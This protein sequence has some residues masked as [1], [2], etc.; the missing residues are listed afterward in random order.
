LAWVL[1]AGWRLGVGDGDKLLGGSGLRVQVGGWG[2]KGV[3]VWRPGLGLDEVAYGF[4]GADHGSGGFGFPGGAGVNF[5]GD[6]AVVVFVNDFEEAEPELVEGV[7][8][9][10]AFE[11][12]V[13][14]AHAEIFAGAGDFG[15]AFVVGD[16]VG[17][18]G[19]HLAGGGRGF[20]VRELGEGV[21][22]PGHWIGDLRF[23][24]G[25]W[26]RAQG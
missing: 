13:L 9:E 4:F 3:L 10:M 15:E 22:P 23:E 14:D 25:D 5:V 12:G 19:E 18:D 2:L 6:E 11:D 26:A 17:D 1:R 16:V 7:G 8:V 20:F 21:E 24:I